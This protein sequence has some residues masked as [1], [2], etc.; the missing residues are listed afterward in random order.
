MLIYSHSGIALCYR[1]DD[2]EF[3]SQ[4]GLGV[5][6]FTIASRLA[7]RPTQPL[8]QWAPGALSLEVKWL[9]HEVDHSPPSNAEV[10]NAWNYT[11]TPP[12]RLHGVMLS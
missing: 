7:L 6:L 3:K 2:R 5:S 9:G 4:Q 10:K 8:I 1:L 11:S 12:I